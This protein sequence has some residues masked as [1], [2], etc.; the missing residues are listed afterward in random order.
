[1]VGRNGQPRL[2]PAFVEFMQ[3]LEPGRLTDV[4]SGG[5]VVRLAGNGVG[6]RQGA[7]AL[8]LSPVFRRWS[9]QTALEAAAQ[10][11]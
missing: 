7:H 5:A 6:P 3:G 4:V 10:R 1:M 11:G 2:A 8:S 9:Q